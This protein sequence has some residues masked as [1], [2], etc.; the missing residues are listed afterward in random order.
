MKIWNTALALMLALGANA[1]AADDPVGPIGEGQVQQML[2]SQG[3]DKTAI[4]AIVE[5]LKTQNPDNKLKRSVNGVETPPSLE[6]GGVLFTH[7]LNGALFKDTDDWN[8]SAAINY[9]GRLVQIKDLYEIHYKNGGLKAEIVY[10][11]MWI[12]LP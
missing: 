12:F 2:A 10:K 11:W 7:G 3:L 1:Q 4:S 8:F 6:L 9:N 5:T